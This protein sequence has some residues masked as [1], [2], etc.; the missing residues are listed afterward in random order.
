MDLENRR[1]FLDFLKDLRRKLISDSPDNTSLFDRERAKRGRKK[2]KD[3]SP[4]YGAKQREPERDGQD[5]GEVKEI[6][7]SYNRRV[8][9]LTPRLKKSYRTCT[10][11]RVSPERSLSC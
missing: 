9:S 1:E 4:E 5:A 2:G 10:A 11:K 6:L 7:W 3:I 8:H